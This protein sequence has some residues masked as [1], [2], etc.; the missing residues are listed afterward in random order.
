MLDSTDIPT[1]YA[2]VN[3]KR[4]VYIPVTKSA[5]ASTLAVV[6]RVKSNIPRFEAVVPEDVKI[7][8][9]FDQSVYVRRGDSFVV[10]RRGLGG[11]AHRDSWFCSFLKI[12]EASRLF[13]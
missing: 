3:G 1:C 8:Y 2:L 9:E 13:W 4:T 11:V 12:C 10:L 5:E 7:S 6:D